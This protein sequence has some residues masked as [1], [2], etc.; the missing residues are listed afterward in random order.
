VD[1]WELHSIAA[2]VL[3]YS[4]AAFDSAMAICVVRGINGFD[5][6]PCGLPQWQAVVL[7]ALAMGQLR[8]DLMCRGLLPPDALA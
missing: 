5:L 1:R 4:G 6:S 7:E 2:S 3:P 8:G